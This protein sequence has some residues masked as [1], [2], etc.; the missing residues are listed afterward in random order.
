[1]NYFELMKHIFVV[2]LKMANKY[3]L[4]KIREYNYEIN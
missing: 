1:M 3:K 4:N 2:Y